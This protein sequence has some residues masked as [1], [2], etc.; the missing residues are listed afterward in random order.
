MTVGI[1]GYAGFLGLD[2]VYKSVLT[3]TANLKPKAASHH[4]ADVQLT[5]ISTWQRS[6]YG[7]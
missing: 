5:Q 3:I 7:Q 6:V 2:Y 4:K 1:R